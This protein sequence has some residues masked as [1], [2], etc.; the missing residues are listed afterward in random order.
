[1][2]STVCDVWFEL[3]EKLRQKSKKL[4]QYHDIIQVKLSI[5]IEIKTSYRESTTTD[6][7]THRIHNMK[8]AVRAYTCTI[9]Q[10]AKVNRGTR[11]LINREGRKWLK[12]NDK[13]D[14]TSRL[15]KFWH[16]KTV[17]VLRNACRFAT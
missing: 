11:T 5:T 15:H 10:N 7:S 16:V 3:N 9:L 13:I 2:I 8:V 1:M 12:R 17:P 4:S 6:Y 14:P